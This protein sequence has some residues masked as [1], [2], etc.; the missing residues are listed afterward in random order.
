MRW[1]SRKGASTIWLDFVYHTF[2][3]DFYGI[4]R[5]ISLEYE[6]TAEGYGP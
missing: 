2:M 4:N 3:V 1:V 6:L 5:M